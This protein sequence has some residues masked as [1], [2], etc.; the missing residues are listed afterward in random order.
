MSH[1]QEEGRLVALEAILEN[2]HALA[3]CLAGRPLLRR[4]LQAFE[5]IPEPDREPI[6]R[7]LER[8]AT[9]CRIVEQTAD[10]TGIRVRPNPNA[11][12]YLHVLTPVD[13][14]GLPLQRD[15]DVIGSGIGRFVHLLPLLFQEGVHAQWRA[16]AVELGRTLDAELLDTVERLAREVLGLIEAARRS[17]AS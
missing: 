4:L 3:G 11:S 6:V 15:L 12:L 14:G 1:R 5:R 10:T 7:V 16:A 13:G 9:W 2:A 17:P 8:D